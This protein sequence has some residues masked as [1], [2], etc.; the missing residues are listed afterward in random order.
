MT[1]PALTRANVSL[2]RLPRRMRPTSRPIAFGTFPPRLSWFAGSLALCVTV[3]AC[4]TVSLGGQGGETEPAVTGS[5]GLPCERVRLMG[6]LDGDGS[7]TLS[8]A[9]LGF[10]IVDGSAMAGDVCA[11][12]ADINCDTF[13]DVIDARL[14]EDAATHTRD[15]EYPA[16]GQDCGKR[17]TVPLRGDV[18]GDGNVSDD[19]AA[20]VEQAIRGELDIDALDPGVADVNCS[21]TITSVDAAMIRESASDERD[22]NPQLGDVNADG[23]LNADDANLIAMY[24]VDNE[25]PGGSNRCV[26]DTNCDGAIDIVDAL[27]VAQT[28]EGMREGPIHCPSLGDADGDGRVTDQ[29][30]FYV[31]AKAS[32]N[33]HLLPTITIAAS[34]DANCDGDVTALDASLVSDAALGLLELSC[35][36][37]GDINGD[38]KIGPDDLISCEQIALGNR[39]LIL[40]RVI[41]AMADVNCDNAVDSADVEAL[42]LAVDHDEELQKCDASEAPTDE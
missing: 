11:A 38:G 35:W 13:I 34:M 21:L 41:A 19:D 9:D 10:A 6:D 1:R 39:E 23:T 27:I 14:I 36:R 33:E 30:A 16:V 8:D 15:L 28:I 29:D 22:L 20:V 17:Q 24:Y 32:G 3:A 2:C 26:A 12:A 7:L 18:N 37:E 25:I 5:G 31:A 40:G 4:D 42:E